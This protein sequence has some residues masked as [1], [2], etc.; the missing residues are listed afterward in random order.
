MKKSIPLHWDC[1]FV[2]QY[3][4]YHRWSSIWPVELPL[5]CDTWL[6]YIDSFTAFLLGVIHDFAINTEFTVSGSIGFGLVGLV[7]VLPVV[8]VVVG[9]VVLTP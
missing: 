1:C 5:A 7:V 3:W 8:A 4:G 6:V 9:F 2:A